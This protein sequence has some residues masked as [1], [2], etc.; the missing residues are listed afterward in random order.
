MLKLAKLFIEKIDNAF[1]TI[2]KACSDCVWKIICQG[3]GIVNRYSPTP[4]FDN[5]SVIFNDLEIFNH[6]HR[7]TLLFVA[8]I[9]CKA[10]HYRSGVFCC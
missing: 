10:I 9:K 5:L 4:G 2:F 6:T 8:E 7:K 1:N 3:R